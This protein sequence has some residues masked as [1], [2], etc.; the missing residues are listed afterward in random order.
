MADATRRALVAQYDL[1]KSCLLVIDMQREGCDRKGNK[2][3]EETLK[4]EQL[5]LPLIKAY[6]AKGLPVLFPQNVEFI[7]SAGSLAE[8]EDRVTK[9]RLRTTGDM[10]LVIKA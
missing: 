5:L 8:T 7:A 10:S 2:S 9:G 3:V 4:L 6:K 1:S